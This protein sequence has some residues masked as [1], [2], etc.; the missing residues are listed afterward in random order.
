[1]YIVQQKV[2]ALSSWDD[3]TIDATVAVAVVRKAIVV[4]K[5]M[6]MNRTE[7]SQLWKA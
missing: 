5:Q 7:Q 3:V 2:I 1:M 6:H 4:S